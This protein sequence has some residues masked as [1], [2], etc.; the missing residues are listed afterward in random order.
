MRSGRP[1]AAT[2]SPAGGRRGAA[3]LGAG[4]AEGASG[5]SDPEWWRARGL[6]SRWVVPIPGA[7]TPC[8]VLAL[9]GLDPAGSDEDVRALVAVLAAPA[10][11]AIRDAPRL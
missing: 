3:A 4:A 11:V 9:A 8:G 5:T 1:D 2:D 10:G 6:G 7:A